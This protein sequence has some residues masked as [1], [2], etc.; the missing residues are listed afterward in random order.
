MLRDFL[1]TSAGDDFDCGEP[2][3][4]TAELH[5]PLFKSKVHRSGERFLLVS[6]IASC[7]P[8]C[9]RV[10]VLSD[11]PGLQKRSGATDAKVLIDTIVQ[12]IGLRASGL[13]VSLIFVR[14]RITCRTT[15]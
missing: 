15:N 6:R 7:G 11:P 4:R 3:V 2:A 14:R 12:W 9:W 1:P 8:R 10:T 5:C 13:I